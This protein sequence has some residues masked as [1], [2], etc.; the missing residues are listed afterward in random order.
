VL[1]AQ[2]YAKQDYQRAGPLPDPLTRQDVVDFMTFR[3]EMRCRIEQEKQWMLHFAS[4]ENEAPVVMPSNSARCTREPLHDYISCA[5]S[6]QRKHP[7]QASYAE[8]VSGPTLVHSIANRRH[9]IH[10]V[11]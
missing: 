5:V 2:T 11:H 4:N 7:L 6:A 1:V 3:Q 8:A 9:S 10:C